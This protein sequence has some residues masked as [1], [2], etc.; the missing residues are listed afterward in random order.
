MLDRELKKGSAEL[1]ILSSWKRVRGVPVSQ[2]TH[3]IGIRLA[4]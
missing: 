1:L 4:L 3:E 2:R